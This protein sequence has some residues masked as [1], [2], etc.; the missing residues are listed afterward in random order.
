VLGA[1]TGA[2]FVGVV[3][4][5]LTMLNVPYYTQDFVKGAVLSLSRLLLGSAMDAGEAI[6]H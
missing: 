5:G 2:V 4:N 1:V 6:K 3:L